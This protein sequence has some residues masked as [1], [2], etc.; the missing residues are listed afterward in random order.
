[1]ISVA[2]AVIML[3][4]C[5]YL[6]PPTQTPSGTPP[7]GN[8]VVY[9]GLGQSAESFAASDPY[10]DLIAGLRDQGWNVTVAAYSLEG[11]T[12]AANMQAA[13][14]ADPTGAT[15]RDTWV[16]EHDALVETLPPGR[17]VVLGISM[18]G[19]ISSQIAGRAEHRPD[20]LVVHLPALDPNLL[21]EFTSYPLDG[22]SALDVDAMAGIPAYVSWAT[23][24]TRVGWSE[25]RSLA[26]A[27]GAT[28]YEY[29]VLGHTTDSAVVADLLAFTATI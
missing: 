23:D 15:L 1:M 16:A 6:P 19:L 2:A 28:G 8:M 9:H 27:I 11:E 5:Q 10:D 24:D 17:T 13:F 26:L 18:G 14:D 22:L 12:M 25:A 7:P 21:T 29:T 4:G 3:T 20:A